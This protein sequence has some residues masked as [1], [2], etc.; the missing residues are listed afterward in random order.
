MSIE[1]IFAPVA[2]P[3]ESVWQLS[4]LVLAICTAIFSVVAGLLIYTVVRFR[5]R[6]E[7]DGREPAQVYGS[8]QIEIAWTVIPVLIVV[9]LTMATAR[10]VSTVQDKQAPAD[11]VQVTLVG[12]Q[13][14]WEIRYPVLGV[15]TANELHVPVS[16]FFKP[17]MTV[18]K[19]Q[20]AHFAP[21][22]GCAAQ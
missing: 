14:W 15:V 12:R 13:W 7:D 21:P 8:S 3:A 2:T 5:A 22:A 17:K 11:S 4:I 9:V 10:A 20:S 1:N 19:L 6:K 16:S 18:L